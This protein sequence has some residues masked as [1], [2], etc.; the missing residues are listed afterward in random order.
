MKVVQWLLIVIFHLFQEFYDDSWIAWQPKTV[1]CWNPSLASS[2]WASCVI[3]TS[4]KTNKKKLFCEWFLNDMLFEVFR[5]CLNVNYIYIQGVPFEKSKTEMDLVLKHI[6]HHVGK[7]KMR[8]K[9][10][11]T[12][13]KI[14]NK[15]MKNISKCLKIEKKTTAFLC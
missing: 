13:W 1:R 9:V 10:V 3:L 7:A 4:V 11:S 8:L 12:F 5:L 6:W 15:Q 14:V 2:L